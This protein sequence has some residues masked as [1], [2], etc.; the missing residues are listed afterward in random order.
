MRIAAG[1]FQKIYDPSI[2]EDTPW[3]IN[4]HTLVKGEDGWHLFGITHK[5]PKKPLDERL[6]AHAFTEDLLRT[7]MGKRPEPLSADPKENEAHFWAP[8]VV[9]HAG[10]YYM[11]YCAG[12]LEGHD[13][14]RIHLA[15]STDLRNWTRHPENPM[16]I[17]GFDA[18]DPMVIRVG[19]EWVMYY[20]CNS[21]PT[22]GNHCVAAVTSTD[23]I[24][25]GNKRVV[26]ESALAGTYGG[27]CESPFVIRA[28]GKYVLFIGPYG[29]YKAAYSKTAIYVSDDPFSFTG[30][31]I[32]FIDAHAAE[33][34]SVDGAYYITHCGW[35]QGGVYL[36]PLSIEAEERE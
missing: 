5:E 32:G 7:P 13:R 11:F 36:A 16:L 18:R 6:C 23:L 35:G 3:Y 19:E 30:E 29:G 10:V 31:P 14:Y 21:T 8:H 24:H 28:H 15:T 2:G 27:P 1:E 25:W 4:D 34:V 17:D 9:F 12:S 33:I 26:F 20:T 22:G